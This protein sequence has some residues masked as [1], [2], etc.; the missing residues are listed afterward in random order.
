MS[1]GAP[2]FLLG[3]ALLALPLWLHRLTEQHAERRRFSSLMFMQP[4]SEQRLVRRRLR[5]PWLLALKLLVISIAAVTFARPLLESAA[6]VAP[7]EGGALQVIVLDTSMS[8]GMG[9]RWQRARAQVRAIASA[10]KPGD[11]AM[12]IA[13]AD[14]L[15][16]LAG[17]SADAGP[18]LGALTR[19][20]P[21]EEHLLF[22]GLLRRAASLARALVRS[23]VPMRLHLVSDFQASAAAA[24][25]GDLPAGEGVAF[26]LH[27]VSADAEDNWAVEQIRGFAGA[28]RG[29]VEVVVKSYA[30]ADSGRR[31]RLSLDGEP[32]AS[33]SLDIPAGGRGAHRFA[34]IEAPRGDSRLEVSLEPADALRADNL[35]RAV[36]SN[37]QAERMLVMTGVSTGE[38][39]LYIRAAVE[40]SPELGFRAEIA[41]P[42]Q[43]DDLHFG[44]FPLV[45]LSDPLAL[46]AALTRR[47]S[48]YLDGGGAAM[49]FLGERS[50]HDGHVPLTGQAVSIA[51][52]LGAREFAS[53]A[54]TD[55]THP[56]AASVAR[57]KGVS[58]YR[59]VDVA[60]AGG[61]RVLVRLEDGAPLLIEHVS[62][63]GRVLIVASALD[64]GWSNLSVEPMFIPWMNA[65]I[66]YLS[67]LRTTELEAHVVGTR[68][69]VSSAGVQLF[70][71]AG[72]K[73]LSLAQTLGGTDVPLERVGFYQLNVGGEARLIAVNSDLRESDPT[74]LEE[75]LLDHWRAASPQATVGDL[76]A[77]QGQSPLRELWPWLMAALVLLML[78]ESLGG[79]WLLQRRITA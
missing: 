51:R 20:A 29:D 2:L 3:L 59:H 34:G 55:E 30:A 45:V 58:F 56:A 10:L 74:R 52:S 18:I 14:S 65:A 62:G 76:A 64:R 5:H 57:W 73:L 47:L 28:A 54:E 49:I 32:I 39:G 67:G 61:D 33:A 77:R 79:N 38:D 16:V 4:G 68:F 78:A 25:F 6:P 31:L 9:D 75:A 7:Q 11:E 63:L 48:S 24:R 37:R 60:L 23:D 70:D 21:G 8:M 44:D 36:I 53:V 17:P 1:L 22:A 27:D 41:A 40:A 19:A 69:K 13:A 26:A 43:R 46:D 35:R 50:L 71:P 15:R 72:E 12:L 66:R 42:E